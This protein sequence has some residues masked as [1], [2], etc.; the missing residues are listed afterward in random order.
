MPGQLLLKLC[1]QTGRLM[2]AEGAVNLHWSETA[3][4]LVGDWQ[5]VPAQDNLPGGWKLSMQPQRAGV[6]YGLN[7]PPF[8][9]DTLHGHCGPLNR[10]RRLGLRQRANVHYSPARSQTWRE[11]ELLLIKKSP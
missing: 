2:S 5:E 11:R 3:E 9:M 8:Y 6:V 7:E 10:P 1:S 4:A